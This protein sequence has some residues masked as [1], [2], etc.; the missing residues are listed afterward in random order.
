MNSLAFCFVTALLLVFIKTSYSL[1]CWECTSDS[2]GRCADHFNTTLFPRQAF[3]YNAVTGNPR[4]VNCDG[5]S[6]Q[7]GQYSYQRHVCMK[8]VE[9]DR[10]LG[11]TTYSRHCHTLVGNERVGTCPTHI[12]NPDIVVDFCEYCDTHE[13]NGGL[14]VTSTMWS[15]IPAAMALVLLK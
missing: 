2:Y 13:C 6:S 15:L 3:V 1:Q 8:R 5:G 12:T 9:T 11:R 4:V 7:Y 10:R 14:S